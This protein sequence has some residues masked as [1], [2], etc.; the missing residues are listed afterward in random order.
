MRYLVTR[1]KAKDR[2]EANVSKRHALTP[3]SKYRL[4][5]WKTQ[6]MSFIMEKSPCPSR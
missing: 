1:G 4:D 6:R 3:D 5:A 2:I